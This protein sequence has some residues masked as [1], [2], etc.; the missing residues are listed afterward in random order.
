MHSTYV[1]INYEDIYSTNI[2][3]VPTMCQEVLC[4]DTFL[5]NR[6]IVPQISLISWK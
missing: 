6:Y 1:L 4:C 5:Q 2:Y 3:R